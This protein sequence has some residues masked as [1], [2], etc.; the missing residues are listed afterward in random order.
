[1]ALRTAAATDAEQLLRITQ[2]ILGYVGTDAPGTVPAF[3]D[4]THDEK[5]EHLHGG[6]G[7]VSP[8]KADFP[9]HLTSHQADGEHLMHRHR[10]RRPT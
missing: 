6:H 7:V 9:F 3:G 1:V 4:M 10:R 5:I 2:E 8:G